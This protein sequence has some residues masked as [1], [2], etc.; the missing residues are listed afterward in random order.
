MT[1]SRGCNPQFLCGS[2]NSISP[3]PA[4]LQS[5]NPY[6][7]T[8]L[9]VD[10][11]PSILQVRR[12]LF[13]MEGYTVFTAESGE[14]ALEIMAANDVDVVVLDYLMPGLNGEETA[15][16]MRKL[17]GDVPIVMSSGCLTLPAHV[18][19]L[20]NAA[21]DK[22]VGPEPLLAAVE[23]QLRLVALQRVRAQ[24]AAQGECA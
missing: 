13:E 18:L 21:V 17:R 1:L 3:T 9:F 7:K 6:P 4:S 22:I 5:Q 2:N 20:V 16:R 11:E 15:I 12:L 8:I 23:Q 24:A 19:A 10:D 14:E